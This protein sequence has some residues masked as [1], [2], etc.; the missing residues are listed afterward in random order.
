MSLATYIGIN[1]SLLTDEDEPDLYNEEFWIGRCFADQECL[2]AVQGHHFSTSHVY[3]VTS[4]WGI[5]L[6]EGQRAKDREESLL[7]LNIL[8]TLLHPYLGPGDYFE[9]YT[10]W[11]GL[12]AEPREGEVTIH[13]HNLDTRSLE[14]LENTLVRFQYT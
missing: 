10:C 4:H 9:L 14:I 5:A 13:M 8:L 12:E 1:F 11:V 7:K 6:Y 2:D 3:E